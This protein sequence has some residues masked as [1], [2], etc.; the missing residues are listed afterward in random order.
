MTRQAKAVLKELRKL[1]GKSEQVLCFC[2][3]TTCICVAG[4]LQEAYDY[5][6]Y[7]N[8]IFGIIEYLIEK[9][10]LAYSINNYHF[11]LTQCGLHPLQCKLDTLK[12]FLLKSVLVPVIVSLGTTLL[13]LFVK[14]LLGLS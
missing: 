7:Q 13:T 6:P 4:C 14:S 10:Y 1:S 3:G 5:S 8:E 9:N 12:M 11:Y 2:G